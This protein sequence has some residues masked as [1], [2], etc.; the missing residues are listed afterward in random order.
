MSKI[1]GILLAGGR[2]TR[3]GTDKAFIRFLG[4]KLI[5]HNLSLLNALCQEVLISANQ[6]VYERFGIPVINDK[7]EDAGPIGGIHA[8]LEKA[9]FQYSLILSCDLPFLNQSLLYGLLIH[10]HEGYDI[11]AYQYNNLVEPLFACYS[12]NVIPKIEENIEQKD[13][14]LQNLFKQL[15]VKLLPLHNKLFSANLNS[16]SDM[17][18]F[19]NQFRWKLPNMIIVSGDGRN[20]GKTFFTCSAIKHFSRQ[21][22]VLAVKTSSHFHETFRKEQVINEGADYKIIQETSINQK[23]SSRML[24]AGAHESFFIMADKNG[25]SES[26]EQLVPLFKDKII[27]A[28]S[29]GLCDFVLPGFFFFIKPDKLL[30]QKKSYLKYQPIMVNNSSKGFDFNVE[31]LD[32]RDNHVIIKELH[33]GSI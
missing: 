21:Q 12:K 8:C 20:V 28:E 26:F 13:F 24:Q 2:S 5:E 22:Q 6:T 14:K 18:A 27:I 1:S 19:Q 4:K 10:I 32:F 16:V 9:S 33:N 29:G 30:I 23:D 31:T 7:F 15:R 11:I 25:L 17:R 3:M